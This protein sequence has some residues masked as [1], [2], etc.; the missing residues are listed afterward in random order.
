MYA[1]LLVCH[2]SKIY[3]SCLFLAVANL[4]PISWR[5]IGLGGGAKKKFEKDDVCSE[6]LERRV[7][8]D[9]VEISDFFA[10]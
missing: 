6:V 8:L 2:W 9:I 3:A 4:T 5:F 7:V 1:F 10:Q